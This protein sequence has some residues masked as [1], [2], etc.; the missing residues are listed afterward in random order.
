MNEEYDF[1]VL[2]IWAIVKCWDSNSMGTK[3]DVK[4]GWELAL[5]GSFDVGQEGCQLWT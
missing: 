5:M 3:G 2:G 4:E 1:M